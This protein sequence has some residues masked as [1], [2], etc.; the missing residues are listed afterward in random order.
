MC[1]LGGGCSPSPG[2][3]AELTKRMPSRGPQRPLPSESPAPSWGIEGS[4]SPGASLGHGPTPTPSPVGLFLGGLL[5]GPGHLQGQ[6]CEQLQKPCGVQK[7]RGAGGRGVLCGTAE[8]SFFSVRGGTGPPT[9]LWVFVVVG[10]ASA[11]PRTDSSVRGDSTDAASS[12]GTAEGSFFSVRGGTGPPTTLR[13][14]VV[15]EVA[16]APP[17]T[18]SFFRSGE[19]S[20]EALP[21]I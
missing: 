1:N 13:V 15:V 17:R 3:G 2:L 16:S 8:G 4:S 7:Q 12:Y 18:D 14:F 20:K 11:P 19:A 6:S 10:V 9:T 21:L 5:L